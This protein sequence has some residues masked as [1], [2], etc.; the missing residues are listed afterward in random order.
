[1]GETRPSYIRISH[2]DSKGMRMDDDLLLS[3]WDDK[4]YSSEQIFH[5]PIESLDGNTHVL[6]DRWD[7]NFRVEGARE[8][9]IGTSDSINKT[10]SDLSAFKI[11]VT[12][13]TRLAYG[14]ENEEVEWISDACCEECFGEGHYEYRGEWLDEDDIVEKD[15]KYYIKKVVK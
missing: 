6:F 4:Y 8:A 1:M 2:Y 11:P 13:Y 10:L 7:I 3:K 15:G 9:V 12:I 5:D 14:L